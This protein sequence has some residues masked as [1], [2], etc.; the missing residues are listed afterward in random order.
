MLTDNEKAN[1]VRD[2]ASQTSGSERFYRDPLMAGLV[3]TDGIKFMADTCGAHWLLNVVA[4]HQ[5]AMRYPEFQVWRLLPLGTHGVRVEAWSDKPEAPASEDGPASVLYASQDIDY[6]DF[7]RELL[8][9]EFWVEN[10][11]IMLK[12][13]R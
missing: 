4:S 1:A 9:F 5:P 11:T 7:P 2:Y 3:Y 13:E 12:E 6:S 10:R 8:P